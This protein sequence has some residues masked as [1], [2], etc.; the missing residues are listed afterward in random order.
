MLVLPV[1]QCRCPLPSPQVPRSRV[2]VFEGLREQERGRP[3]LVRPE[4][5]GARKPRGRDRD[6]L[7]VRWS[8]R[9]RGVFGWG[10]L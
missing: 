7:G 9:W 2:W 5:L 6:V 3:I 4:Y 8:W 1:R 10:G